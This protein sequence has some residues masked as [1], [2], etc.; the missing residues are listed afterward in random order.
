MAALR[1][2]PVFW[3]TSSSD[4]FRSSRK[5]RTKRDC[6][7]QI[8]QKL[9]L[10]PGR[11]DLAALPVGPGAGEGGQSLAQVFQDATVVDDQ[12]VVLAL[13]HPVGAGDGLHQGMGLEGLVQV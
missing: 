13:V 12:A 10:R 9:L 2:K 4:A 6:F 11:I 3:M 5:S 7:G 8:G 1:S